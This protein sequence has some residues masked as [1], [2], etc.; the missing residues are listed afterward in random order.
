MDLSSI[1]ES[2]AQGPALIEQAALKVSET[3]TALE[4]AKREVE[5]AK[6]R[7]TIRNQDAKNQSIL[8]AHVIMDPEVDAAEAQAIKCH[9]DYLVAVSRHERAKDEF[10]SAKKNSNLL[11]AEMRSY[12]GNRNP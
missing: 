5:K 9:A 4:Q 1:H 11:E 12:Q 8:N 7:A 3:R 6:A 10:D 2:L